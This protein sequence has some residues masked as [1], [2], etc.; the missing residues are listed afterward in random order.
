MDTLEKK[1]V[2]TEQALD[3]LEALADTAPE[4]AGQVH[5]WIDVLK[6]M[7]EQWIGEQI[8]QDRERGHQ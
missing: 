7:R 3:Y 5:Q 1:I 8:Q 6:D 4:L 2:C